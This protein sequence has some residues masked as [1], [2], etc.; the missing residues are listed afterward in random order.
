MAAYNES[1]VKSINGVAASRSIN[2]SVSAAPS[3][4]MK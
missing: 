4:A 3:A 1:G 2:A